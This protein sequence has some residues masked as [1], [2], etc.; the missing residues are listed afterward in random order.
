VSVEM[1]LRRPQMG[2]K[3]RSSEEAGRAKTRER[4]AGPKWEKIGA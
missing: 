2:S 1:R 4:V 3:E